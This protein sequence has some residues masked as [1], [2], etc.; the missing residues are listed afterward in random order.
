MS[1]VE[2]VTRGKRENCRDGNRECVGDK[3]RDQTE[4]QNDCGEWRG[5][6]RKCCDKRQGSSGNREELD[7]VCMCVSVVGGGCKK[8]MRDRATLRVLTAHALI[9][10]HVRDS[11]T[12]GSPADSN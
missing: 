11:T 2:K 1:T 3:E 5:E 4:I 6:K 7:L 9:R 10:L 8:E 12:K